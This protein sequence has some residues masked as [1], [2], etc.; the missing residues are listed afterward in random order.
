MIP[1]THR[2]EGAG[3]VARCGICTVS[4]TRTPETDRGGALIRE[5]LL[6]HAHD[7][8]S[9]EIVRDEPEEIND[10][11]RAA[12][13]AELDVLIFSGGTGVSPRDRTPEIVSSFFDRE[14]QGFG[15]LFRM[16]SYEDIGAA[17]FLSR[18]TAG[19]VGR[20]AVFCLPGS[21]AAVRLA[22]DKLLLPELPHLLAQLNR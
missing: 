4:D 21:P 3:K 20:T 14:L 16:L 18:A 6:E 19:I 22:L 8:V 9:Y 7:V 17:A 2:K 11:L 15:E 12:L 1:E 5:R 13:V 10:H